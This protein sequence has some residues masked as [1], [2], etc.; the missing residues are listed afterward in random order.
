MGGGVFSTRTH[1]RSLPAVDCDQREQSTA[2]RLMKK[3]LSVKLRV[4]GL[5]YRAQCAWRVGRAGFRMGAERKKK[6]NRAAIYGSWVATAGED[7]LNTTKAAAGCIKQLA[8]AVQVHVK[9]SP[10]L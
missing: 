8:A 1:A 9:K 6:R 7:R 2:G 4:G 5:I 10:I 3:R